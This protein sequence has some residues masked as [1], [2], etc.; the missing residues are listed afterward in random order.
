MSPPTALMAQGPRQGTGLA[1]KA[2][3]YPGIS[4]LSGI[5]NRRAPGIIDHKKLDP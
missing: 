1:K 5:K 3:E 2:R 4:P